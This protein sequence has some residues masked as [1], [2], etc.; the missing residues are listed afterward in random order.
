MSYAEVTFD[1]FHLRCAQTRKLME[2]LRKYIR[3]QSFELQDYFHDVLKPFW[4]DYELL[5]WRLNK[6]FITFVGAQ[7]LDFIINIPAVIAMM[8]DSFEVDN[9]HVCDI[10]EGLQLWLDLT[11]FSVITQIDDKSKYKSDLE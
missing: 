7:L 2:Y 8:K 10:C 5:I 1:V 4:Q 9:E 6:P 3:I 11:P